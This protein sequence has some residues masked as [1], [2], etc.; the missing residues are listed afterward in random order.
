MNSAEIEPS[1]DFITIL[2]A[3]IS[4]WTAE[5]QQ[6]YGGD[7]GFLNHVA[8]N[9]ATIVQAMDVQQIESLFTLHNQEIAKALAQSPSRVSLEALRSRL[10]AD[11]EST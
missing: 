3:Q 1:R 2:L 11:F 4:G 8:G 7:E 6:D 5:D 9:L 10:Q